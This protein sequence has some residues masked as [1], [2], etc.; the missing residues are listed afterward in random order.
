MG[1]KSILRSKIAPHKLST[2]AVIRKKELKGMGI[3]EMK[4]KLKELRQE[5]LSMRAKTAST[6]VP[7][8]SGKYKQMKKIIARIRT[9]AGERRFKV[10]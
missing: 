10:D 5:L 7:D 2:M 8:N 6:K 3:E 9:I 1:L 4:T